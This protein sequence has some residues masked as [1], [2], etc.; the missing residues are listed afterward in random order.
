MASNTLARLAPPLAAF[1][2]AFAESGD[3]RA[4]AIAAGAHPDRAALW[5]RRALTD[6]TVKS[7][8]DGAVRERFAGAGVLALDVLVTFARNELGPDGKPFCSKDLQLSAAKD[9]A[10]RAGYSAKSMRDA[11][12]APDLS[13][14]SPEQLRH[15]LETTE[16]ELATR[17]KTAE[18]A[19][20]FDASSTQVI[21]LEA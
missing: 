18:V 2:Q 5:G 15:V 14:M 1:A 6:P 20:T 4:A 8:I 17:A 13:E 21:D 16:S 12:S 9:L 19:P 10:N 7:A 3:P 11:T